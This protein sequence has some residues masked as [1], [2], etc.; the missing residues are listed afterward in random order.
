MWSYYG[1]KTNVV[2]H[3]PPPRH[4]KIIEPFAGTARYALRYFDRE[5]L[6]VDKYEVIIKIW[7]FLQSCSAND[8]LSLP[9]FTHGENI[10]N[11][12]YDCEEQRL[13]MGFLIGYAHRSPTDK[14]TVRARER[15]NRLNYNINQVAQNLWKIKHWQFQWSS[16]EDIPDQEATWFIDPPYQFGGHCYRESNRNIDFNLLA[17]W[18]QSRTGQVIVCENTKANWMDFKPLVSQQCSSGRNYEAIWTNGQSSF[19]FKQLSIF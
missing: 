9:R 8:I 17:D 3:Y 10:N 6:L 2:Q 11:H 7:K 18:C 14:A 1:A 19:D 4:G 5:V 15:P 16:Y 13:L 12:K